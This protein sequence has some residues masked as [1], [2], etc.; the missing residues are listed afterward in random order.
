MSGT[1][2]IFRAFFT[3]K[4]AGH[5][6]G[7]GLSMANGLTG[8]LGGTLEID[9]EVGKGTTVTLWLQVEPAPAGT[10]DEEDPRAQRLRGVLRGFERK[11]AAPG[12]A[13]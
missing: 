10:A 9:S 1:P 7:L 2:A 13:L 5:G 11:V 6:T 4:P 3:T 8:Q 12:S